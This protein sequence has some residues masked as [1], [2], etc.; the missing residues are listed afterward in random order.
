MHQ[1]YHKA[2]SMHIHIKAHKRISCYILFQRLIIMCARG[3][4]RVVSCPC[5]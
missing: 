3:G 1:T 2:N 4:S 5:N